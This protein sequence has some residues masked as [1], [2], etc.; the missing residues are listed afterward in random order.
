LFFQREQP[1]GDVRGLGS[2]RFVHVI[3]VFECRR[4]GNYSHSF[5]VAAKEAG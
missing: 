4:R 5:D 2:A 3:S 1:V